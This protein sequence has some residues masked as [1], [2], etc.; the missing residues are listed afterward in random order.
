[1]TIRRPKRRSKA[2]ITRLRKHIQELLGQTCDSRKLDFRLKIDRTVIQKEDRDNWVFFIVSP[3]REG[4]RGD[5]YADA[6][7]AVEMKLRREENEKNVLLLPA[8]PD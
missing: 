1:M 7:T 5:D 6:L 8:L 3:D 2:N 4:V